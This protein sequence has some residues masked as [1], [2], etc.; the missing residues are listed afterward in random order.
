MAIVFVRHTPVKVEKGICY[1][2]SDVLPVDN[3]LDFVPELKLQLKKY[4]FYKVYSSPLLRCKMLAQATTD[5]IIVYDDRL[6]ELNFGDWEMQHWDNIYNNSHQSDKWFAD[7]V[8]TKT[9][10][11]ESFLQ[12]Y[13]RVSN[14][15]DSL[16]LSKDYLV[17]TH[18]GVIRCAMAYF[19]GVAL[20][21]VFAMDVAYSLPVVF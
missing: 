19:N 9:P 7:F 20:T 14:F 11:G 15:I 13:K 18:A 3:Y 16:D 21:D 2:Q 17:F 6:K 1:G 5:N 8:N 12:Q 4:S 10:N